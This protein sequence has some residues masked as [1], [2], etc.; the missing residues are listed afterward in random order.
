MR[1][2]AAALM[3]DGRAAILK[4]VPNRLIT[5]AQ[6]QLDWKEGSDITIRVEVEKDQIR[7]QIGSALLE[8]QDKDHPYLNG[9]VGIGCISGH[10]QCGTI[11]IGK[12]GV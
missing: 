4:K 11:H 2:Y 5:L 9:A 8:C 10:T 6:T 3:P 12:L 7:A 1:Y